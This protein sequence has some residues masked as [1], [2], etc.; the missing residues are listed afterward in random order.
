MNCSV[1]EGCLPEPVSLTSD[2][3]RWLGM[4]TALQKG[5]ATDII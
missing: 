1:D 4:G 3:T 5:W 2:R